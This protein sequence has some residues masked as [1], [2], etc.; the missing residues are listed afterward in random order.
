MKQRLHSGGGE[1]KPCSLGILMSVYVGCWHGLA[2]A[3]TP[4]FHV[5]FAPNSGGF[6]SWLQMH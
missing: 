6:S 1:C 4:Y 3:R 2:A 5:R